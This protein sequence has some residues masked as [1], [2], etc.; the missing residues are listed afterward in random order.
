[1]ADDQ[2]DP[3]MTPEPEHR[4]SSEKRWFFQGAWELLVFFSEGLAAIVELFRP[5]RS[6]PSDSGNGRRRG[7]R[8]RDGRPEF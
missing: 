1:M 6:A 3:R 7:A 8:R 4:Q 5:G 2:Q